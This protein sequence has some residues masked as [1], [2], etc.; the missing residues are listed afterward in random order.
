MNI[1]NDTAIVSD[2]RKKPVLIIGALFV[3]FSGLVIFNKITSQP[4]VSKGAVTVHKT[5]T[6]GCCA[7]Y[8][9]YLRSNGYTV[10]IINHASEE[11]MI[12]EKERI[13]VPSE[14]NSCHTTVF[15]SGKY[16]V[17]GHI[18]LEA[19]DKLL[20]EKP[21]IIGIGMPGMPSASPGMPGEKTEPFVISQVSLQGAV[22]GYLTL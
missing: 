13:G 8:V 17:E 11:S 5:A 12:T 15:D 4:M 16:F 2:M 1:F 14:L 6:C 7:N 10:D 3:V 9:G 20:E 22:S 19:I 18:P 21:S